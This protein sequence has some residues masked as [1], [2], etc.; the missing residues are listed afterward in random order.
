[1]NFTFRDIVWVG[2]IVLIVIVL[3]K[4]HRDENNELSKD[5]TA[6]V[7]E[8]K[9]ADAAHNIEAQ[10][11]ENKLNIVKGQLQNAQEDKQSAED[12]LTK[13]MA[14]SSR[15]AAELK[16]LKGWPTDTNAVLVGQEYISY[17]D[18]LAFTADSLAVDFITFKRKNAYLSAAKDSQFKLQQQFYN[19]EH[20]LTERYKREY[21][22]LMQAYEQAEKR[23]KPTNQMYI[24]AELIGSKQLLVQNVG[25]VL[26]LKTKTNK[27]WQVSGGLQN[28]GG[29]YG[30][31][32]GNILIRLRK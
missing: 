5:V 11:L 7:N 26:S 4:C 1:M 12:K 28:G 3:S 21:N 13:T 10:Q 29:W 17:C 16:R 32:N 18:S 8:R 22:A 30:R 15:L 9:M 31:I 24:G 27:L 25:A 19:N 6:L 23:N 14:T 20:S 2:I